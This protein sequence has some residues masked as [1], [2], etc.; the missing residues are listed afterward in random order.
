MFIKHLWAEKQETSNGGCWWAAWISR[1]EKEVDGKFSPECHS[2]LFFIPLHVCFWWIK[3]NN[4]CD[5]ISLVMALGL[6]AELNF[7]VCFWSSHLGEKLLPEWVRPSLLL[8][9]TSFYT[10]WC[11][12]LFPGQKNKGGRVEKEQALS[13]VFIPS[14]PLTGT[15]VN[16]FPHL[17]GTGLIPSKLTSLTGSPMHRYTERMDLFPQLRN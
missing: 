1:W 6:R 3:N 8:R 11:L 13:D 15:N 17:Y 12:N 7:P 4:L 9:G 16:P 14:R 10:C 2:I 5:Q